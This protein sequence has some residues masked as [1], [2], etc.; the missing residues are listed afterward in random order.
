M[1]R[2]LRKGRVFGF[3]AN[4]RVGRIETLL[5]AGLGLS[6]DL[7]TVFWHN[8]HMP[9]RVHLYEKVAVRALQG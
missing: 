2:V 4:N 3:V 9:I 7:C 5:G 6:D 1:V 8:T